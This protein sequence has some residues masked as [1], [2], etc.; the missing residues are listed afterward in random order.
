MLYNVATNLKAKVSNLIG[1]MMRN[2][3]NKYRTHN[4]RTIE[5]QKCR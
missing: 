1:G 2:M 5:Y 3:E 4:L